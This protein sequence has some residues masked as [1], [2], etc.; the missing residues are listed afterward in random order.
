MHVECLKAT[1]ASTVHYGQWFS[2]IMSSI[3]KHQQKSHPVIWS[4][5]IYRNHMHFLQGMLLIPIF[6]IFLDFLHKLY[7]VYCFI[8][9]EMIAQ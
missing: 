8:L 4:A 5:S 1:T 3:Y 2:I 9:C 7:T 6:I